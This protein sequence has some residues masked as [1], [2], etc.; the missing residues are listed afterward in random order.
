MCCYVSREFAG[1]LQDWVC[2]RIYAREF[3]GG[4]HELADNCS[5]DEHECYATDSY[6]DSYGRA[7]FLFVLENLD[8]V[9]ET[10]RADD[11]LATLE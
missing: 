5:N 2:V 3:A 9:Q 4:L 11:G 10:V 6:N 1:G 7:R 8:G